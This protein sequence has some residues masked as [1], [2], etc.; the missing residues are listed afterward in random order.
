VSNSVRKTI[1]RG[2]NRL[3]LDVHRHVPNR[4]HAL[5]ELLQLYNVDMIF[6]VGAN[7]GMSGE[8]FRNL[9]FTGRIVSFEPVERLFKQLEMK[10]G[11]D[12]LWSCEN[13]AVGDVDGERSINLSGDSGGASSFLKSTGVI[14][15]HA[16]ELTFEGSEVVKIKTLESLIDTYYPSGDRLFLKLDAQGYERR[17]IESG[18]SRLD[19]VVGLRIEMSLVKIYEDE[20]LASEMLPYLY[21][22]GFRLCAIEEAWSDVKTHEVFQI[23]ATLFRPESHT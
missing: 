12:S 15:Q 13:V 8:Y 5:G 9:G 22:L 11:Q 10:V 3:G 20:P 17:I 19:R 23:D 4:L 6:D 14:E 16:P 2:L 1:Q 7:I 18:K 21:S